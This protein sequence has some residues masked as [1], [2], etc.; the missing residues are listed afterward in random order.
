MNKM[1]YKLAA[2]GLAPLLILQGLYVRR[3][4]PKLPE[5]PGKRSGVHG[6]GPPLRLLILGDSAAAGVGVSTQSSALSGQLVTLLGAEFQV[7]W[8]LIAQTHHKAK[9]VLEE[10]KMTS[11]EM[12]D[13]IVTSIGVNDV[14]HGTGAERWIT[15]QSQIVELL[16][17]KFHA[18][19]HWCPNVGF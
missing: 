6:T 13:V 2:I 17:S 8:K 15:Q 18:Q 14:T 11:P 4:T 1:R 5:P 12:F 7:F 19:H 10:L 3:V 9:D 16:Q